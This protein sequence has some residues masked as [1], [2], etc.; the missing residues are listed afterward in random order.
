MLY[1]ISNKDYSLVEQASGDLAEFYGV[2]IKTG[3]WKDVVV[4]YGKVGIKEDITED[5]A[6]LSFT[7]N[8]QDPADLDFDELRK[9]EPFNNYLGDLL[10]HII[11][12]SLDNKE[13][14]IGNNESTT[15]T[16]TESS[17]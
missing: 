1:N 4:V 10:Q 12:D 11:M 9:D 6:T 2:R 3:K 7:Y 8:I 16:Y 15:N 14:R 5:Q 17:S 13:A